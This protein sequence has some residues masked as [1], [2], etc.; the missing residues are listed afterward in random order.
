[1]DYQSLP[2]TELWAAFVGLILPLVIAVINRRAWSS[3]VKAMVAFACV[4][5]STAI[6]LLIS[7][8]LIPGD[9]TW[10]NWLAALLIVFLM[11]KVSYDAIWKPTS[12]TDRIENSVNVGTHRRALPEAPEDKQ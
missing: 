7:G 6:T 12:V 1:M 11:T 8:A 2:L 4:L 9:Q 5:I 10:R 3:G